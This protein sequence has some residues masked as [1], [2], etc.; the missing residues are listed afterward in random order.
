LI[1]EH[2]NDGI[3]LDI[4]GELLVK[5]FIHKAKKNSRLLVLEKIILLGGGGNLILDS[6]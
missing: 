3:L 1:T 6:D 5:M 4:P 2:F